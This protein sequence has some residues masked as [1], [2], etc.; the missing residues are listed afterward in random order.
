VFGKSRSLDKQTT[1]LIKRI[2]LSQVILGMLFP[3]F[4]FFI[5]EQSVS[6]VVP[7]LEIISYEFLVT[8]L[9]IFIETIVILIIYLNWQRNLPKPK[10]SLH[11]K[12]LDTIKKGEGKE[13]EF[14]QTLR[15]DIKQKKINKD[16]EKVVIKSI[17]GFLN[18]KGGS[19]LIGV[20]DKKTIYGL[21][22]DYQT[23]PKKNDDGFENHLIQLIKSSIGINFMKFVSID[24]VDLD[25]KEICYIRI[26]SADK[27]VFVTNGEHEDFY[28][29]SGNA[30]NSLGIKD[31]VNYIRDRYKKEES[32]K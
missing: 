31:S 15:W 24:F 6:Q 21:E 26:K 32:K 7:I 29:R 1:V 3:V 19:L 10:K 28:V 14:K 23:L 8:S 5:D 20:A 9:I 2:I 12:A 30:T 11:D 4:G 17:A 25:E 22:K 18:S 27:P 13:I 16:L